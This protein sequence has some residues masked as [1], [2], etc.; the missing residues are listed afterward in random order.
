MLRDLRSNYIKSELNEDL[1][2]NNPFALFNDWLKKAIE[3]VKHDPNAM[4]LT[5]VDSEGNP[6][7]RVVLLKEL[8]SDGLAFYTNLKSKKAAQIAFNNNVSV[9]FFWPENERQVRIKGKVVEISES[10]A[11]DYFLT[12]PFESQVG[13]WASPQSKI[14]ANRAELDESYNKYLGFFQNTKMA[15]PPHWG[16]YKILPEYFEFWQGRSSRLHDRIE[17]QFKDNSWSRQ[18][19]AP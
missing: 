1:I 15:K 8:L 14:I 10:E 2:S 11:I 18:R 7:S 17:Y 5:T 16:G 19:L 9:L 12:R 4:I 13:A 3:T 6:D